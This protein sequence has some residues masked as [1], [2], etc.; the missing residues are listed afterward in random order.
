[1]FADAR[2]ESCRS[3]N[4][5]PLVRVAS[6]CF[7]DGGREE[8][9]AE[10]EGVA[11][12]VDAV[13]GEGAV[14]LASACGALFGG[15][16]GGAGA[17][18]PVGDERAV[19]R[20]G[21]GV[22]EDGGLWGEET[23][24]E[25]YVV[26]WS[27]HD[28]TT[29]AQVNA[30]KLV[31]VNADVIQGLL[32]GV[33]EHE[34]AGLVHLDGSVVEGLGD[35]L[36]E[37][38]RQRGTRGQVHFEP[39]VIAFSDRQ[40]AAGRAKGHA[41]SLWGQ[42]VEDGVGA[43][44]C[45]VAAEVHLN[46]GG[47]PPQVKICCWDAFSLW[48]GDDISGFGDGVFLRHAKHPTVAGPGGQGHDAGGIAAKRILCKG[49]D[50]KAV[51]GGSVGFDPGGDVPKVERAV[52][53]SLRAGYRDLEGVLSWTEC[54][55]WNTQGRHIITGAPIGA[56][57]VGGGHALFQGV[58]IEDI[59]RG[60]E[61]AGG[62]EPAIGPTIGAPGGPR[63]Q[64]VAVQKDGVG[65]F[66]EFIAASV[67]AVSGGQEGELGAGSGSIQFKVHQK[68]AVGERR[69]GALVMGQLGGVDQGEH[70]TGHMGIASQ[71]ALFGGN[72]GTQGVP[73]GSPGV[74][75]G[76][77]PHGVG[78]FKPGLKSTEVGAPVHAVGPDAHRFGLVGLGAFGVAEVANAKG[79]DE[80]QEF[81]C[82]LSLACGRDA[83]KGGCVGVSTSRHAREEVAA[84]PI[85]KGKNAAAFVPRVPC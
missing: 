45:S 46:V 19:G 22:F 15:E 20:A 34:V 47:E 78:R 28:H 76:A 9:L 81:Q 56:A 30:V 27:G 3:L 72:G 68:R 18:V 84:G 61:S 79:R 33:D 5:G 82:G 26:A 11:A 77:Y 14:E 69:I 71:R 65:L 55:Q 63:L 25:I 42:V 58:A 4:D 36:G 8:G 66:G 16:G 70:R 29:V 50:A 53:P 31:A 44:Q 17:A 74:D 13:A 51:H 64:C 85:G 43:G 49:V 57:E 80:A 48:S 41:L 38:C 6:G 2:G 83:A 24:N 67:A 73:F 23:R 52:G 32:I 37:F 35:G 10:G 60:P 59:G 12:Y 39:A 54:S 62:I 40:E 1:M 21:D 7:C 75:V